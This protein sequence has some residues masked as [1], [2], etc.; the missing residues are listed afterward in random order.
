MEVGRRRKLTC[1]EV[2]CN[3]SDKPL[4]RKLPDKELCG[5]LVLPDLTESNSSRPV[6]VRLQDT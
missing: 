4:E 2:L 6:S 3:F 1:L 5:L